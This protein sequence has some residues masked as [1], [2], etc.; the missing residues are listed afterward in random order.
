M[1]NLLVTFAKDAMLTLTPLNGAALPKDGVLGGHPAERLDG[2][3]VRL[4]L[5]C[6]Q[7][8]QTKDVVAQMAVPPGAARSEYLQVSLQYGTS[9][10]LRTCSARGCGGGSGDVDKGEAER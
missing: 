3:A 8:G 9:G 2:G 6:L 10:E 5:G 7:F 1:T 4:A